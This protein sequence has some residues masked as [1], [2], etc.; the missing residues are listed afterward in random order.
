MKS[1]FY[2]RSGSFLTV[3]LVFQLL[4]LF[5]A[6][7]QADDFI[8]SG[9]CGSASW[10]ATCIGDQCSDTA[11]WTYN[12][13][14]RLGCGSAVFPGSGDSVFL[15]GSSASLYGSASIDTLEVGTGGVLTLNNYDQALF[16]ASEVYVA[17]ELILVE[18]GKLSLPSISVVNEGTLNIRYGGMYGGGIL[19]CEGDVQLGG[20]GTVLFEGDGYVQGGGTLTVGAA[21]TIHGNGGTI[22]NA[23]INNGTLDADVAG[24]WLRLTAQPKT[25]NGLMRASTGAYLDI[26]AMIDQT[27]GGQIVADGPG[28]LVRLYDG[29]EI[30]GGTLA[31]SNAGEIRADTCAST[32]T[33]TDVTNEGQLQIYNGAYLAVAGTTLTNNG[34]IGLNYGGMCGGAHLRFDAD[35][36]LDGTGELVIGEGDIDTADSVTFTNAA[37]HTI[38]AQSGNVYAAMLNEGTVQAEVAP[39]ALGLSDNPKTNAG[40]M[41]AIN[42]AYLDIS[43][44]ITQ[45]GG[46]Q[47]VADG[48]G[49]QVR[50]HDGATIVGGVL[51]TN[52]AGQ[53]RMD[54]C[55][56][57]ATLSGLTNDGVFVVSNG[58]YVA[59]EGAILT[60]NETIGV[61]YGGG[62]GYGHL[63]FDT[64]VALEGPG[65]LYVDGGEVSTLP[66]ATLTVGSEQLLHG[67]AAQ[68]FN[69]SMVNYGTVRAAAQN[70]WE[71]RL[72]LTAQSPGITN[73]GTIEVLPACYMEINS[74]DLFTQTAGETVV[75]GQLNVNG[76]PLD[77]QGGSL[78]GVG[79]I[80]GDVSNTGA[81]VE[82]GTS[83]GTLTIN[84][85]YT[86]A[87]GGTL[88]IQLAGTGQYDR[89]NLSGAATLDGTLYVEP[90][91]GFAPEVGQQFTILTCASRT[92]EFATVSGPGNYD[93]TYNATSIVLTIAAPQLPGD[94]DGDCDV[95][96]A[97]LAQLLGHYHATNASYEDGDLDGDG[98]VDLADLAALLGVYGTHC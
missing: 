23:L 84:G 48:S 17:G 6:V 68:F 36:T 40:T 71:Y 47:I 27:S 37:G 77:L 42:G 19:S 96:L 14:G 24:Y 34:T 51:D 79:T 55:S 18:A 28:S 74:A 82:P 8:W 11:W 15:S 29:A 66:G 22:S 58:A 39:Y 95:D 76:A 83:A 25:N 52:D 78:S 33:V 91:D 54:V 98:D 85:N 16:V 9:D 59:V 61:Q 97:D 12:N 80:Y 63:R 21:Q 70:Y 90:T 72:R 64:D 5:A 26:Y 69:V 75:D 1:R 38:R 92:G 46:G 50:L 2:A 20:D 35:V 62:C 30:V 81:S 13:W 86:Q 41:A 49:S 87:A 73:E 45:T 88:H 32:T 10:Y 93:V 65:D 60:N 56:G 43:T 57:T 94:L 53:I 3:A 7:A 67:Y 44:T 89:L 31:T 4:A